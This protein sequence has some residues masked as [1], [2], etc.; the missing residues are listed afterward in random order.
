MLLVVEGE[1]Y[2]NTDVG[3]RRSVIR[4]IVQLPGLEWSSIGVCG[5]K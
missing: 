1:K 5:I 2:R 4:F 3:R